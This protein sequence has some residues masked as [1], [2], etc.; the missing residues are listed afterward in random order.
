M[1]TWAW[2][3]Q[4]AA[5]QLG[6]G[7]TTPTVSTPTLMV[8]PVDMVAA[9]AG[10]DSGG[11]QCTLWVGTDT[12]VYYCGRN[13]DGQF[14]D[15]TTAS[16]GATTSGTPRLVPGMSNILK[17]KPSSGTCVALDSA[18]NLYGWGSDANGVLARTPVGSQLTPI[19][20]NTGVIDFDTST[21]P[22]NIIALK[23]SGVVQT[24][25]GNV[26]GQLA[27][28]T[29]GVP[30]TSTWQ[31]VTPLGSA[32]IQPLMGNIWSMVVR[33]DGS[34]L[35]A[36]ANQFNAFGSPNA[37]NTTFPNWTATAYSGAIR[38]CITDGSTGSHILRADGTIWG[39]GRNSWG[40]LGTG[41]ISTPLGGS[42]NLSSPTQ[43]INPGGG[44]PVG[45]FYFP[46]RSSQMFSILGTDGVIYACGEVFPGYTS[47][48]LGT[49]TALFSSLVGLQWI[50]DGNFSVP[51]WAGT[52]VPGGGAVTPR[53]S[54]ATVIG[55]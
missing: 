23:S 4:T 36:G 43:W 51:S 55:D 52:A 26:F 29:Q 32:V 38:A 2:G 39:M 40:E 18:G 25:G 19:V 15:G 11:V 8:G 42:G 17:A 35:A 34:V 33:A 14:G 9:C 22:G 6:I 12:Q 48:G 13:T 46:Q 49:P 16:S 44:T 37:N 5:G 50:Q 27:N 30:A 31:T 45:I 47:T 7:T 54:W 41:T 1:S 53:R 21:G 24:I 20:I 10:T 28:G 3:T